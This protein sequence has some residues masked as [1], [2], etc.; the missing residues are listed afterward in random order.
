MKRAALFLILLLFAAFAFAGPSVTR[1]AFTRQIVGR[2]PIGDGSTFDSKV[3]NLYF[4][5]NVVGA[6]TPQ[7]IT[8]SWLYNGQTVN[9]VT[10]HIEGENWR[11]W[12]NTNIPP[13]NLGEWTVVVRD[14]QGETIYTASFTVTK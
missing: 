12:S 6:E 10:L 7:D 9:E 11:T 13:E 8:H 2:E 1:H 4:F 5:I 14:S 3:G